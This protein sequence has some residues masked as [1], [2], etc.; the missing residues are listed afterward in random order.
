[1]GS[2]PNINNHPDRALFYPV[3]MKPGMKTGKNGG[4]FTETTILGQPVGKSR[5]VADNKV[6]P[7][8]SKP[9]NGWTLLTRT[10]DDLK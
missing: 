8:T 7:P 5:A 10:P 2:V 1:M 3:I 9:G 6:L 4:I